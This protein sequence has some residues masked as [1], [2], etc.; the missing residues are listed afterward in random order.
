MLS[1]K[2]QAGQRSTAAFTLIDVTGSYIPDVGQQVG[3]FNGATNIW[4]GTIDEVAIDYITN[5]HLGIGVGVSAPSLEALLDKRRIVQS[6]TPGSA[7]T[8]FKTRTGKCDASGTTV[9]WKDNPAA[10]G[11][12]FSP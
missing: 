6:L 3:V 2:R 11:D 8:S 5:A 12:K 1:I 9:T 4:T 10:E 7:I